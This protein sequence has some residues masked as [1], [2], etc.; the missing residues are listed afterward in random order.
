MKVKFTLETILELTTEQ[1][2][3]M[4]PETVI[5]TA[6]LRGV[7]VSLNWLKPDEQLVSVANY[8]D[9]EE[10]TKTTSKPQPKPKRRS[11]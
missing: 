7:P 10:K 2:A 3:R 4:T 8:T 6:R 5:G 11:K 9:P 1:A